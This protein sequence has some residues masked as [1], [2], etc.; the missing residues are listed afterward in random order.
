[1]SIV[2]NGG[3][4]LGDELV[5]LDLMDVHDVPASRQVLVVTATGRRIEGWRAVFLCPGCGDW[6]VETL[7]GFGSGIELAA[8]EDAAM[9]H[10]SECAAFGMLAG[11]SR[12]PD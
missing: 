5:L 11:L 7:T 8:A 10:R 1:M 6:S 4:D 9:E 2:P 12:V 3:H